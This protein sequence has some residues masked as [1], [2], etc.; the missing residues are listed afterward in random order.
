MPYEFIY[1]INNTD[2]V[3]RCDI[4]SVRCQAQKKNG[5]GRCERLSAIGSPFCYN[6][7]LSEK[8]LR[9][10]PSNTPSAGKGLFAQINRAA[11]DNQTIV[12]KKGDAIIQYTGDVVDL[13]TLNSRYDLDAN[14]Q[15]TAPYAYEI[16]R[17]ESFVD[18]ACNRGIGSLINHKPISKANATFVKTRDANGEFNGVKLKAKVN[19]KNNKEI[20]ASYGRSYRMKNR[21]THKTTYK[22]NRR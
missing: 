3:F 22:R 12:F 13:P 9:I 5:G 10:K 1:K 21:T 16:K 18:S 15:F 7:L 17:D 2:H 11:E 6:H 14:T 19:I 20:F 4:N 8:K